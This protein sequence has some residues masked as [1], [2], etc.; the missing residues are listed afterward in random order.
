MENRFEKDSF[1]PFALLRN[2]HLQTIAASRIKR[3]CP[4]DW[5]ELRVEKFTL[6]DSSQV[7]CRYLIRNPEAPTLFILHG[8]AGSHNSRYIMGLTE[9]TRRLGWNAV[10]PDMYDVSTSGKPPTVFHSGC[11][12]LIN[13]LLLQAREKLELQQVMLAGVS[14]GGNILLK[15]IGEWGASAPGW[16]LAAAAIS[17]L[18]DLPGSTRLMER[19][20]T[21]IYRKRFLKKLRNSML[22]DAVRYQKYL[23]PGRVIQARTIR[24]FDEAFTVP[25]SG[26][27]SVEEYYETQ[28]SRHLLGSIR[29]PLYIIHSLD[30][31]LLTSTA[32]ES[33][34]ARNNSSITICLTRRGGHV[35]F[36]A[37]SHDPGGD[38][39]WAEAR[40]IDYLRFTIDN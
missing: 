9:K 28:S 38:R 18:T 21:F 24:Q 26:F 37:T 17:P 19:P 8:M 40:I 12:S 11:S 32:L 5:G 34:P 16:V 25:L 10:F 23:D 20:S 3:P 22:R 27:S 2:G 4:G 13:D 15:M 35:G 30:D 14:M 7:L 36:L 1:V 33:G 6:Y 29:L 39:H 31:P